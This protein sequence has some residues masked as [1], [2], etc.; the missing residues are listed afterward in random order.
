MYSK[1]YLKQKITRSHSWDRSLAGLFLC[2]VSLHCLDNDFIK[3]IMQSDYS[4]P[5]TLVH[6]PNGTY[7][8]CTENRKKRSIRNRTHLQFQELMTVHRQNWKSQI[9]DKVDLLKGFWQVLLMDRAKGI[10]TFV[11][12]DRV[13][14]NEKITS[15]F[16]T[17]E[18]HCYFWYRQM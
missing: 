1:I 8:M 16:S 17:T 7:R 15:D 9:C 13:N 2:K 11:S 5:C 12:S 10:P 4:S 14:W 6:K 3:P 18:K